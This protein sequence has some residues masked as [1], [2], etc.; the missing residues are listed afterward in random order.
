[1]IQSSNTCGVAIG[2]V[3]PVVKRGLLARLLD[4]L[5][6]WQERSAQRTRLTGVE[7]HILRD[8]GLTRADFEQ[9]LRKPFWRG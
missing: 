6:L 7:D 1:M 3:G 5:A 9:E 4:A 2:S 8:I